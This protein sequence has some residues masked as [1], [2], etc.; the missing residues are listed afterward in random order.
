MAMSPEMVVAL[1]GIF[2]S[3][4]VTVTGFIIALKQLNRIHKT[5]NS[6][7]SRLQKSL[8]ERDAQLVKAGIFPEGIVLKGDTPESDDGTED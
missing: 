4:L 1:G 8:A 5:T 2:T 6:N 7:Y 3:T